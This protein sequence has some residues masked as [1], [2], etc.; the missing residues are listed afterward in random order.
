[1]TE[2][3]FRAFG[4]DDAA[5]VLELWNASI[6]DRYLLRAEILEQS[7]VHNPHARP[8][9]AVVAE[10]GGRLV[11]LAW[12]GTARSDAPE[13]ANQRGQV[14][15]QA[16]VVAPSWRRQGVG[17]ALVRAVAGI[18]RAAGADRLAAGGGLFYLW[19]GV[20]DDLAAAA[21][22][23]TRLGFEFAAKPSYDLRGDVSALSAATVQDA[24][25][26]LAAHGVVLAPAV[27][28]DRD[29][30]LEFL[31]AEFGADWWHDTGW[32]L[33]A[34]GDPAELLL[35]R[36]GDAQIRGFVRIHTP[37]SRPPGWPMYWHADSPTAGG[38]GP[39]G[40]AAALRG[41]GLGR[42]LL[43]AALD[44]LRRLGQPDVVIDDT[45]LLGYY[46]PHGFAPWITYHHAS[47]PLGALLAATD[48]PRL[49]DR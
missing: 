30:L 31:L 26:V 39:I 43:V 10:A 14:W 29:A 4:P 2:P 8:G 36:A 24:D 48:A 15:L 13:L 47:A 7:L 34:G 19:P 18:G 44:R 23:L 28:R 33:A 27:A 3:A 12:A 17:R 41:Q 25:A 11:G 42:A 5:A 35:L 16:V 22:F 9:D 32:F 40:V 38:L 21:P 49:E 6:G 45:T 37:G 20:P 46:G 1:M